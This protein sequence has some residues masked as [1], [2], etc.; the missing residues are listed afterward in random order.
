MELEAIVGMA[1]AFLMTVT[2][3]LTIGGVIL[4]KPLMR[5]LGNFLQAK[6][7]E[8]R[9]SFQGSPEDWDRLAGS[10]ETLD[11]R[12]QAIEERQDF[13]EKLL[14]KPPEGERRD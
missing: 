8:R 3:T 2:L 14:S 6:A 7:D 11:E 13:T 10:L 4:L 1:F 9:G 5:N 12:L